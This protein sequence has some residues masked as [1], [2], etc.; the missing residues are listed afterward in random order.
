M[1]AIR[2]LQPDL[3]LVPPI[4]NPVTKD[5]EQD[6]IPT[7]LLALLCSLTNSGYNG[8][9]YKPHILL[10]HEEHIHEIAADILL[11]NPRSIGFSTW[12]QSFPQSL[13]IARELKN[14]NKEI[15]IIFGGPQISALPVRTLKQFPFIDYA[16]CGEADNSLIQLLDHIF[17][18]KNGDLSKIDGLVYRKDSPDGSIESNSNTGLIEHLDELPIPEYEKI[19][20]KDFLTLDIG[21][22]CPFKCTYC[23][24]NL[25]FSRSYR[26]KSIRR[27]VQEI[28][29]CYNKINAT[30]FGFTH[31]M[32]TLDRD[33]MYK[34]CDAMTGYFKEKKSRFNWTCSARTD[35]VT[36]DLLDYM[37]KNGCTGIFFGI[38]TGSPKMQKLIK[39]NL[40]LADAGRKI[41]RS[42]HSGIHTVVSYMA[43]FPEE[44]RDDFNLTLTSIIRMSVIGAYPQMSILT[45]LPGTPLFY[46][47]KDKLK[48]DG[49]H[50]GFVDILTPEPVACLVKK[51]PELFSPYFY[52]NDTQV[53]RNILV[54]VMHAVNYLHCFIPTLVSIRDYILE[55]MDQLDYIK[56][57]EQRMPGFLNRK[58]IRE[59][60]ITF[61]ANTLR[62]YLND[63]NNRGLPLYCWSVFY[64][65]LTKV[66]VSVRYRNWQISRHFGEKKQ[67]V[68][69]EIRDSHKINVI[70]TWKLLKSSH[71][72]YDVLRN[73][74][75][76]ME[77]KPRSGI[78]FYVILAVSDV[79]KRVFKYSKKKWL[80]LEKLKNMTVGEFYTICETGLSGKDTKKLLDDLV[81]F[82]MIEV[83]D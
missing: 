44:S 21:R 66:A 56:A 57:I 23:S 25:F 20:N 51:D 3:L 46:E 34:L 38:E 62:E 76:I 50:S 65:D 16:L 31:D 80:I 59:P 6:F 63:L 82:N 60:A 35:C 67:Q 75:S 39:K 43:G 68:T 40:D 4:A 2:D 49:K 83:Y 33:F 58:S 5:Q 14:I 71:Y 15:P 8:Q 64:A 26:T 78:Y 10:I 74:I 53:D 13:L 45:L 52:V 72:V 9:I 27:I 29:Y 77:K 69:G 37:G 1:S 18:D 54:F 70:P 28:D 17:Q 41:N 12:C 11:N 36:E 24:T 73:P 61:I 30:W 47:H 42:V 79:E 81:K 32:I 22:G 7:G 55:D 48:Y 19:Y